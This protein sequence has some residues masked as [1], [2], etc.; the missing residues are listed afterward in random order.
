MP[1]VNHFQLRRHFNDPNSPIL[2]AMLALM[3]L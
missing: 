1:G 2:T 3:G